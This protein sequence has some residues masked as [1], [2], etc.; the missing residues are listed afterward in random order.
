MRSRAPPS[1]S[2][3]ASA[4]GVAAESVPA[5]GGAVSGVGA[6]LG[7]TASG[8]NPACGASSAAVGAVAGGE[9]EGA[10]ASLAGGV[11]WLQA[12]SISVG[13]RILIRRMHGSVGIAK[14][15]A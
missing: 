13:S 9:V 14:V 2:A 12:A 15:P 1:A 10:A 6:V 7:S 8:D 11:G 4:A 3:D 5:T